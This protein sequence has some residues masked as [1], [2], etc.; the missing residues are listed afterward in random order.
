MGFMENTLSLQLNDKD[1]KL[2]KT[3]VKNA[4]RSKI[5]NKFTT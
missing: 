1:R 5:I 4:T 3:K 2:E